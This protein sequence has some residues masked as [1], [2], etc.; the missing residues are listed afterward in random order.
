M[1]DMDTKENNIL[2]W[3]DRISKMMQDRRKYNY[4]D[5]E[6]KKPEEFMIKSST[7]ISG[8]PHIGN[9]SD[10]IRHDSVVRSLEKMGEKVNFIWVSEDMDPLRKVPA[11]IP[12]EFSKYLGMPVSSLPCPEGCCESYVMHFDRLFIKSLHEHFGTRPKLL[13]T[14]DAYK[15]GEFY[16]YIKKSLEKIDIIKEILNRNRT[17]PLPKLYSPWTPVCDNC[18]KIITTKI[19]DIEGD[20]ISYECRDYSFKEF[21]KDA[22]TKVEGCGYKGDSDISK[23]NGKLLWKIEWAAEWPLWKVNFEGAGK[24]HFMPGGSFWVAG[25]ITE[26]VFDWPEPYPGENEIQ[27][28]EYIMVGKEKMSASKGNVVATWDWPNFAPTEALRLILLK[29]P[30][31][32]RAF[33][34][35]KIPELVD[36]FDNL[37]EIYYGKKEVKDTKESK[38]MRR[39][40]ESC[41][42]EKE[43]HYIP[44][45]SFGYLSLISQMIPESTTEN[46][47]KVCELL[48]ETGHLERMD[49]EI[50]KN[51]FKRLKQAKEWMKRYG[52]EDQKVK[53]L[54]KIPEDIV[55]HLSQE[56]KD[57][58]GE[59]AKVVM[60][61]KSEQEM[62]EE[63]KSIAE[64]YGIKPRDIFQAAYLVLLGKKKGPRLFSFI[65]LI[66]KDFVAN[67]F[68][69]EK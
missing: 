68:R 27:P 55:S 9:A 41:I 46:F 50:R 18:G 67:R 12:K 38:N 17:T 22:Y 10:V 1:I 65:Q 45:V 34:Y 20:K 35:E 11:G 13:S 19:T 24:E 31:R 25:E 47:D 37:K 8:V 6:F 4:L 54:E 40:Y 63:M 61:K 23:G 49:E 52:P 3:S 57:S 43:D 26:K 29:R 64:K 66:D 59:F 44:N 15:K 14:T 16:S 5:K 2:F 28:Y 42:V 58:L 7:S 33:L 48:M 62:W 51:V 53:L 21:G 36:E 39:L 30:N 69:L 60:E 32:Q 56:Q